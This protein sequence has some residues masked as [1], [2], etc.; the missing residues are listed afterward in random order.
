MALS[1]EEIKEMQKSELVSELAASG[2]WTEAPGTSAPGT[3]SP[4]TEAPTT[5]APSAETE[6]PTT[7]APAAETQAPT[8]DPPKEV[9]E[10]IVELRAKAAELELLQKAQAATKAFP[11]KAPTTEAPVEEINFLDGI[12]EEDL[13]NPKVLNN[14]LNTVLKRGVEIGKNV[15]TEHVLRSIPPVMQN[16]VQQQ[17]ALKTSVDNFFGS[18]EDLLPHRK[19]VALQAQK[20]A[21]ENPEWNLEKLYDESGKA[22]RDTIGLKKQT[23]LKKDEKVKNPAFPKTT[24]GKKP[25]AEKPKLSALAEEIGTM[26]DLKY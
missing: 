21:G 19:L 5:E 7:E 16:V 17:L 10:E 2:E 20:L 8:T 14:I 18:N 13:Q 12:T 1:E 25:A 24:K 3:E 6:A 23:K 26:N 22:T 4:G 11:T 9:G 15:S